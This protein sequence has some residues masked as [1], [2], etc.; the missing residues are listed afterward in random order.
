MKR[1]ICCI[2]PLIALAPSLAPA[3]VNDGDYVLC[4]NDTNAGV[5]IHNVYRIERV[6]GAVTSIHT[7][8][9][10]TTV[11]PN[12]I[13][14]AR[15]NLRMMVSFSNITTL[16]SPHGLTYLDRTG[17]VT[18][19][20]TTN[21]S[22]HN[23][24]VRDNGQLLWNSIAIGG[25]PPVTNTVTATNDAAGALTTLVSGFPATATI[26]NGC[27]IEDS[28]LF[29]VAA[30]GTPPA[31]YN[32]IC[33]LSGTVITTFSGYGLYNTVDYNDHDGNIYGTE[34]GLPG[35]AAA[36]G[37]TLWRTSPSGTITS[38]AGGLAYDRMNAIEVMQ[39]GQLLVGSRHNLFEMDTAGNITRTLTYQVDRLHAVTG[40]TVY[41]SNR[42]Q[43]DTSG[44]TA[45][46]AVIGVRVSVRHADAPGQTY[47]LAPS[48]Y[49]RPTT[50]LPNGELLDLFPD[51]LTLVAMTG[52]FSS[53]FQNFVG[54][55]DGSG[56]ASASIRLPTNLQAGTQLRL[57][58]AGVVLRP[59]GSVVA[60]TETEGVTL[61]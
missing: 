23:T 33:S 34:F 56:N 1:S 55:L 59:N 52:L 32:S 5:M 4:E 31:G 39:T 14:M 11:L 46:G 10:S 18:S 20:V 3:Q 8:P 2:L 40:A 38:V 51:S 54:T 60:V 43:L 24:R 53:V 25:G 22:A 50:L 21:W 35:N 58:I 13:T 15:D 29:A 47:V 9:P 36:F 19:T 41:G 17:A 42:L 49:M 48:L 28:G 12:W 27:E 45:P 37:G 7:V 6:S 30:Q 57:F 44:G 26:V 16:A 61:N